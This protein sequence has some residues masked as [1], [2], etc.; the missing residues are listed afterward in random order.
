[1][2]VA[3]GWLVERARS[4]GDRVAVLDVLADRAYRYA[5]LEILAGRML[6]W[7]HDRGIQAGDRVALRLDN[8]LE[9]IALLYA[10]AG[11]GAIAV[12]LNLRLSVLEMQWQLE[13]A[14]ARWLICDRDR[15][16]LAAE[17]AASLPA[18]RAIAL[19]PATPTPCPSPQ[20]QRELGSAPESTSCDLSAVQSICY[21]SGTTGKPKGALLTYGNHYHNAIAAIARLTLTPS[22]TWLLCLPLYH[23]GGMSIL[24]RSV[25]CGSAIALLPK[26]EPA[27]V[28]KTIATGRI[29]AI[30]LV[31]TMLY[32]LLEY[33]EFLATLPHW[34]Q[35]RFILLGGA[36]CPDTLRDRCLALGLPIAPTYGLTEAASQVTTLLPNEVSRKPGAAGRSLPC[37]RVRIA[38]DRGREV[39]TGT[40][41][42]IQVSGSGTIAS[43]AHG[44]G[45]DS[46]RDG[47][48]TTGDL[49]YLDAEG[50]L[51]VRAR[52]SDLIVCG[53]ENIYP[54]EIEGILLQHPAIAA[55]CVVG[56]PDPEWGHL[57]VVA[58]VWQQAPLTLAEIQVF[59]TNCGL[60]RYK[61][62]RA[63]YEF[64]SLPLTAS[65]KVSRDRVRHAIGDRP[66]VPASD[67][68][69]QA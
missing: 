48:F 33:E 10:L 46:F 44:C 2:S 69:F 21:T 38:D 53:G 18:V 6:V 22:D 50:Y 55:A 65:G 24:W 47:W 59:C 31:P 5:D 11:A 41:G 7:L 30:S 3:W 13:D 54:A 27:A 56:N 37:H 28:L 61:L 23:V 62:P 8:R 64:P 34:Q 67:T 4:D 26:F 16:D 66:P 63:L 58:I 52:R 9:T 60:A 45:A 36:D 51:Y 39:P 19:D 42:E 49:G 17:L 25:L 1:M 14:G 15:Q 68:N 29:T 12:P 57:P 32:R 43:Y 40:L 20:G 35:L